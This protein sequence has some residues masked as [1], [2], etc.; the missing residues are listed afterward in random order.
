MRM[1]IYIVKYKD[2]EFKFLDVKTAVKEAE[3]LGETGKNVYVYKEVDGVSDE[4]PF[5]ECTWSI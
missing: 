3:I 2:N 5:F 1:K 4:E